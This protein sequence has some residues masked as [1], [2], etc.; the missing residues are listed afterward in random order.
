[1]KLAA[2]FLCTTTLLS[3]GLASAKTV[4]DTLTIS[5]N[6][7]IPYYGSDPIDPL[8]A[9]FTITFDDA[10]EIYPTSSGIAVDSAN[11]PTLTAKFTYL[12]DGYLVIGTKPTIGGGAITD[13]NGDYILA[14]N[15]KESRFVSG[16]YIALDGSGE[17]FTDSGTLSISSAPE[18]ATWALYFFG[19]GLAGLALRRLKQT[20]LPR[21]RQPRCAA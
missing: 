9:V 15:V 5:A 7:L 10:K 16:Q 2:V 19:V 13:Q 21:P 14:V 1:M 12:P 11:F 20:A 8:N 17:Y 4:T 6:D 3:G 18:P